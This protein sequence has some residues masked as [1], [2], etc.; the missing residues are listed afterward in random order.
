MSLSDESGWAWLIPLHN[1]TTSVGVVMNQ[2]ISINKKRTHATGS[3]P[4]ARDFYL[5]QLKL[6]P[7]L[8]EIISKD[9]KLASDVKSASDYSYS[10]TSYA[11]E[12]YRIVGDAGGERSTVDNP[13]FPHLSS[14]ECRGLIISSF[15]SVHRPILLIW[16]S[17]RALRRTR[18]C[19]LHR[20]LYSG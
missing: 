2:D 3:A 13:S 5:E 9:G 11:G 19:H 17:P 10:A 18:R 8:L 15:D 6:A 7:G 20:R 12:G 14:F 1:G 16:R 4:S